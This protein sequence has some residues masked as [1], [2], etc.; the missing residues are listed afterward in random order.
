[1]IGTATRAKVNAPSITVRALICPA[2]SLNIFGKR[3]AD[4]IE[5]LSKGINGRI[6]GCE[7]SGESAP[8]PGSKAISS[9][10]TLAMP[11]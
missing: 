4:L 8:M 1:M 3:W 10:A 5:K 9:V 11:A 7:N 2:G 6:T